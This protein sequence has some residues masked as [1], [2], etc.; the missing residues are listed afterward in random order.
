MKFS[1]KTGKVN[2]V[3][4]LILQEIAD[5]NYALD[6]RLPS[7]NV[8]STRFKVSRDTVFK[9]Y[10]DLK[11][12]GII[13]SA[14]MKGYSVVGEVQRVL[15]LLDVYSPFKERLYNTFVSNLPAHV[16]VD[17]LFHQYNEKLFEMIVNDS[18]GKYN[19]YVV[20]N[21]KHDKMS[22]C[23]KKL[24]SSKLLLLD[25]C[26]FEKNQFSY[27]SQNFEES[28]YLAL[29]ASF[30]QLKKYEELV[31]VFPQDSVHPKDAI[32]AFSLFCKDNKLKCS[33]L[34]RDFAPGDLRQNTAYI[35]I[36]TD[37]LVNI[38]S[39]SK[40][41]HYT[42]GKE[43]GVVVYNDMPLLEVIQE[44]IS[45][46]SVNFAEMGKLAADFVKSH[47]KIEVE[48]PTQFIERKSL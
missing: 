39:E 3:V 47:K 31:F 40:R 41:L 2:Q 5:G 24:P 12:R 1:N 7:V 38:I 13:D 11:S 43:L 6:D 32:M 33:V 36:A 14:P 30:Q 4:N 21:F 20:M 42:F 35:A 29:Q 26:K 18:V 45:S 48:M 46:Y 17:L 37:D 19:S 27:I 34:R 28:F 10:Q 16:K 22:S 23:L 44:G 8:L 9:A 15:L 25:F